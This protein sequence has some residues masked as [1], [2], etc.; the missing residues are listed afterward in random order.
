MFPPVFR[1]KDNDDEN[2]GGS[3]QADPLSNIETNSSSCHDS[4]IQTTERNTTDRNTI[5]QTSEGNQQGYRTKSGRIVRC[6][7]RLMYTK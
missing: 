3:S 7:E 6:P 5:G 4:P 1:S 2:E